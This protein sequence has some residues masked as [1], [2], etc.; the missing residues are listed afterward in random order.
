M[1][2]VVDVIAALGVVVDKFGPETTYA[3]VHKN[4]MGVDFN[5][6]EGCAY[7]SPDGQP[8]CIVGQVIAHLGLEFPR[9]EDGEPVNGVAAA[10]LDVYFPEQFSSTA[11]RALDRAQA[12][13]DGG[14]SWGD[15]LK[16]A[17]RA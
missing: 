12:V 16:A 11:I 9:A 5:P 3:D 2:D 6:Y 15:A 17:V 13:Q 1:F 8:L 4:V 10:Y 7:V 14:A